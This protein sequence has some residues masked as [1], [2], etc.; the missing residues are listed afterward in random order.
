MPTF[1]ANMSWKNKKRYFFISHFLARNVTREEFVH[2]FGR[3]KPQCNDH[4]REDGHLLCIFISLLFLGYEVGVSVEGGED[5]F[6]PCEC[7]GRPQDPLSGLRFLE[8]LNS[9]PFASIRQ[10]ARATKVPRL[11]VFDH[12]KECV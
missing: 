2:V 5:I 12:L 1:A 4:L 11:T 7:S 6:E 3:Q 9:T 10:I 8:F